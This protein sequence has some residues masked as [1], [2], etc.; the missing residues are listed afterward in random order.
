M[1]DDD[2]PQTPTNEELWYQVFA[3]GH[4]VL[5][6][7]RARHRVLPSSPRCVLCSVPF[8]GPGGWLMR[9]FDLHQSERNPHYCNKC[10]GFLTAFPGGAEVPLSMLMVDVRGSTAMADRLPG[11]EMARRILAMRELLHDILV[12]TKGFVL[13]YQG[14]SLFAVWPPGF[15]GENH[16]EKA[17]EAARLLSGAQEQSERAGTPIGTG[18]HTGQVYLGTIPDTGGR[19]RGIGAFGRNVNLLARLSQAASSGQVLV[20]AAAFEA[21]GEPISSEQVQRLTLKGL[22]TPVDVVALD[23]S[24]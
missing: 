5:T 19:L 24:A 9:R 10:D 22:E 11:A 17:L 13:E 6:A 12:R 14:D 7:K 18:V 21:A 2:T 3:L 8:A 15:V 23:A 16:A 4:P 20:S 1:N